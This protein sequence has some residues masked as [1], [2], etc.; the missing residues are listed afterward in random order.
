[1]T[2]L[3]GATMDDIILVFMQITNYCTWLKGDSLGKRPYQT[4]SNLKAAMHT[5]DP[6]LLVEAMRS[7][8]VV[9][10]LNRRNCALEIFKSLGSTKRKLD[11]PPRFEYDFHNPDKVNYSI[12]RPN[13]RSTRACIDESFKKMRMWY[14]TPLLCWS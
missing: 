8:P 7:Y 2:C 13:T 6:K 4:S 10:D 11:I 5:N 14:V 3:Y 1:M 9:K 12:P